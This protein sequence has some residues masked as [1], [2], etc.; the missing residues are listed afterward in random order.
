MGHEAFRPVVMQHNNNNN[1]NNNII[2]NNNN[3]NNNNNCLLF[4]DFALVYFKKTVFQKP[5]FSIEI[6]CNHNVCDE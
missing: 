6:S 2:N 3:N 5:S 4:P 1:N